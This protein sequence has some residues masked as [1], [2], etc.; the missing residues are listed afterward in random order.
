MWK[1]LT[2]ETSQTLHE[3]A[4]LWNT[5]IH[6]QIGSKVI[7]PRAVSF[8][9]LRLALSLMIILQEQVIV[10]KS[11]DV[12]SRTQNFVWNLNRSNNLFQRP[13][14]KFVEILLSDASVLESSRPSFSFFLS[15]S[16]SL[17]LSL[18]YKSVIGNRNIQ[19]VHFT[20]SIITSAVTGILLH[21]IRVSMGQRPV[22]MWWHTRRNQI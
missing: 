18:F 22:E 20:L 19:Y 4:R 14:T 15:L 11:A 5:S 10:W 9:I 3:A 1:S 8:V 16:L 2:F 17:S 7:F 12:S 13:G 6:T 21:K